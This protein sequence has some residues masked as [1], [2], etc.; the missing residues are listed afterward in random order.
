MARIGINPAR[1]KVSDYKPARLT[2]TSIV[3]IPDQSGYFEQRLEVLKLSLGSLRAHTTP[4]YDLMLFDNGS[5]PAVVDFL[6]GLQK[7]G[8]VDTLLLARQNIGKI[9]ALQ[10][11]FNAAPGEI[12]A[13]HDDDIFFYPGWLEAHLAIL[14]NFPQVGM[15]SGVPVRNAARHARQSLERIASQGTPGLSVSYERRIPAEWETD[16]AASTGRDPQA[17]L[18][19]TKEQQDMVLRLKTP[20]PPAPLPGGEGRVEAIG[21][22]NH[23]QFV[24]YKNVLLQALPE[25]WTGKLMGHMVELDEAVDSLGKLRLST[26]Q[27]FTRHMGNALSPE[28]VQEAR[29]LG[30]Q[31]AEASSTTARRPARK[32]WLLRL[33]GGRRLLMAAYK[34]LFD[35]LYR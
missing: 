12:I 28:L 15:V 9:G 17:H 33:P 6:R 34:R 19:E 5:C 10:I 18:L 35:I 25:Q 24:A 1:G 14:E 11:L 4:P 8:L 2:V 26:I 30:L 20:S 13:Y 16:W 31:T 7:D 3:Y 21:S 22:A 23:F 27:R 29:Q 32:H